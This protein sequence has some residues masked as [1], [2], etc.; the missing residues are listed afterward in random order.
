MYAAHTLGDHGADGYQERVSKSFRALESRY[1][2]GLS[3]E[4]VDRVEIDRLWNNQR[5]AVNGAAYVLGSFRRQFSDVHGGQQVAPV[6][7][8]HALDCAVFTLRSLAPLL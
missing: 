7:V 1:R 5:S 2:H 3:A 4:G 6:F 8:Q